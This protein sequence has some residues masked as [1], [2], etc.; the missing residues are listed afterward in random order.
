MAPSA[1]AVADCRGI[2]HAGAANTDRRVYAEVSATLAWVLD[3]QPTQDQAERQMIAN[4]GGPI[5]DTLAWL[6]GMASI[7]PLR[8]PRRNADG[9]VVTEEQLY[10]ELMRDKTGLPEQRN[11][12]RRKARRDAILYANLAA[13]TPR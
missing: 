8:L 10:E 12:A 7:P 2:A 1:R 13:L 4:S 11:E 5:G 9:S 6:V 3:D